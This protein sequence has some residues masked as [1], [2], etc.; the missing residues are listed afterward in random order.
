M[1]C[2]IIIHY[3]LH[4][5]EIEN[6]AQYICIWIIHL[7]VNRSRIFVIVLHK[8][9][10]VLPPSEWVK[11]GMYWPGQR[12]QQDHTSSIPALMDLLFHST[13]LHYLLF[14]TIPHFSSLLN[15]SPETRLELFHACVCNNGVKLAFLDW[16]PLGLWLCTKLLVMLTG[17]AVVFLS[18]TCK[19]GIQS[20]LPV[21]QRGHN[22]W[23]ICLLFTSAKISIVDVWGRTTSPQKIYP[24]KSK[25]TTIGKWDPGAN[26]PLFFFFWWHL[27]FPKAFSCPP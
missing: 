21:L 27:P 2:F 16:N 10:N 1:E 19:A 14:L 9:L 23:E 15:T 11:K 6:K 7:S 26:Q 25:L 5:T 3:Y 20:H 13:Y 4:G 18:G 8:H 17:F 12:Y 24:V 22:C